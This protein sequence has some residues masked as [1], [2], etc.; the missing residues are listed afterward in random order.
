MIPAG[1]GNHFH[2]REKRIPGNKTTRNWVPPAAALSRQWYSKRG[3][4][5]LPASAPS[6]IQS[7]AQTAG[8]DGAEW[9][10]SIE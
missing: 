1:D 5:Q 9:D 8:A 10:S 4:K 2:Y 6:S 3:R 7:G